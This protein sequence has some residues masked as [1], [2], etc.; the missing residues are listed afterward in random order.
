M[1][2]LLRPTISLPVTLAMKMI[3][4]FMTTVALVCPT[5]WVYYR[6]TRA[7][8]ASSLGEETLAVGSLG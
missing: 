7:R 3:T 1:T 5:K 8:V 6:T 2:K 4:N